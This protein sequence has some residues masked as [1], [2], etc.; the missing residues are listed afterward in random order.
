[1][2][3]KDHF[4]IARHHDSRFA[5][6]RFLI[7]F[8]MVIT[9]L[10]P[11]AESAQGIFAGGVSVVAAAEAP[12]QPQAAPNGDE[13]TTS[14]IALGNGLLPAWA[15]SLSAP[16]TEQ[17]TGTVQM[18]SALLPDWFAAPTAPVESASPLEPS[19]RLM[20][21][22]SCTTAGQLS[23]ALTVPAE[24][25]VGNVTGD[26][27]TVTVNNTGTAATT[28]ARLLVT[29][30]P[31]FYYVAG[32]AA[33]SDGSTIA[34][35]LSPANPAPGQAFTIILSQGNGSR[36]DLDGG[37]T[38]TF[39][40]RLATN[41]DAKSG[42]PLVTALQSGTGSPVTC[43]TTTENVQV[44][45]GNLTITK[46]PA[47]QTATF[48]SVIT[49]TVSL[50]N[51]GQGTLYGAQLTDTIGAGYTGF[52]ITPTPAPVDLVAG[53]KFDYTA[54]AT[55]NSCGNLTNRADATWIL[56]NADGT[57]TGANPVNETADVLL[58]IEDPTVIVDIGPLPTTGYCG[59]L[60]ATI[61]V[62]VTNTGGAARNVSLDISSSGPPGTAVTVN[63]AHTAT[64]NKSGNT[65]TY[66][67]GTLGAGASV[68]FLLDMVTGNLCSTASLNIALTPSYEDSCL[69]L[70]STGT[71][72]TES[73]TLPIEA[74][75]L[76][77]TKDGPTTMIAGNSYQYVMTVSGNNR[78]NIGAGGVVITDVVPSN[79]IIDSVT[80]SGGTP[81]TQ[82]GQNLRWNLD[83]SGTGAYN[84]Q[85]FVNVTVPGQ[86]A[87]ACGAGSS[88]NNAVTAVADIPCPECALSAS[89]NK[90]SFIY[91]FLNPTLNTFIKEAT[92]IE[93][94]GPPT[95]NVIT[96]TL[97][98]G[99]G[100][101]WTNTI[102]TD[103][104]GAGKLGQPF[105]IVPGSTRVHVDGID[106]TANV[107]ISEG[108]PLSINFGGLSAI[109]GAFS[110]TANI[111]IVYQIDGQPGTIPGGADNT[112]PTLFSQFQLNGPA[113]SCSGGI[114]G[115]VAVP[116]DVSRGSLG[117]AVEP[118]TLQACRLNTVTLTVNENTASDLTDSIAVSFTTDASDIITPTAFTVGGGFTGQTPAVAQGVQP[119]GRKIVTFTFPANFDLTGTGTIS[120][121]LFRPCEAT[122]GLTANVAYLDRCDVPRTSS[123]TGGSSTARSDLTLFTTPNQFTVVEKKAQWSFIVSNGGNTSATDFT[124][125]NELPLGTEFYT[126]TVSGS[127]PQG[128]K[129]SITYKTG[130]LAGGRNVV[131]FTVPSAPGLPN[132]NRLTFAV[133]ALVNGCA[134]P[135]NVAIRLDRVC[136]NVNGVCQGSSQGVVHLLP[137]TSS[138]LSTNNQT[139]NLPLCET[140]SVQL[141]VKN[142]SGRAVEY[143]LTITDTITNATFV[144]GSTLVSVVDSAGAPIVGTTSGQ[145]LTNIPFAP[146]ISTSGASS[147]LVWR[148]TDYVSGTAAYDVLAQRNAKDEIRIDFDV[149][150]GCDGAAVEV[151]STGS[152]VDAC[153]A[154]LG[155]LESSKS[156]VTDSPVLEITKQ[157]Q[158]VTTGSALG[159]DTS[160]APVFA[161]VGDQ[162]VWNVTVKNTGAQQVTNLFTEDQLPSNFTVGSV[163]P[164]PS[165]NTGSPPFLQWH[166]GGGQALAANGGT[167]T[168]AITGTLAP[169]ACAISPLENRA[170]TRFA[171]GTGDVC[172][173]TGVT[174]TAYISTRPN[175]AISASNATI[176]ECA[177]GPLTVAINNTGARASN[178][179]VTYT[180]PANMAY[181]GLNVASNPTPTSQPAVGATGII[182]FGYASFPGETNG[183]LQFNATNATGLCP[184]PGSN[185][186]TAD[187][188]Y[189]NTCSTD[190]DDVAAANATITV[191]RPNLSTATVTPVQQVVA[192]GQR[193]TWTISI[194]NSGSGIARNLIVT[195]TLDAGWGSITAIN[196]APGGTVP[197]IDAGNRT[198]VWNVGTLSNGQTWTATFSAIAQDAQTDYRTTLAV[199]TACDDGGCPQSTQAVTFST[200]TQGLD[201]QT[202]G[203]PVR[204][205]QPFTYTISFDFFG[206][207]TYTS[208]ILTDT[209]PKL[210]GAL[211]FS[212]TGV[213]IVNENS[214]TNNWAVGSLSGDRL[215]FTTGA[216]GTVMGPD[217]VAITV[218]GLISNALTAD[219]NDIF[220]NRADLTWVD[221]GRDYS[222]N[223]AVDGQIV[224]PILVIAKQ[225]TPNKDLQAGDEITYT[226]RVT[227]TAPSTATAFD[228]VL[229][230]AIPNFLTY[231]RGFS[232]PGASS[233][234]ATAQLITATYAQIPLGQ[235]VTITY[236]VDVHAGAPVGRDLINTAV[237]SH[238]SMPGDNPSERTGDPTDPGGAANDHNTSTT[239]GITVAPLEISKSILATNQPH[240]SGLN[241]AVGEQI[242][243][244]LL[245]TIP[246]GLVSTGLITDVLDDGLAFVACDSIVVS[247]GIGTNLA[248]DFAAACSGPTVTNNGREAV[249][250]LGTVSNTDTN[251]AT[252][253]TI[254][255]TYRVVLLNISTTNRDTKWNNR[256]TFG[257]AD[258][259]STSSAP[260]V[261]VVEPALA[262][263]KTLTPATSQANQT[264]TVTLEIAHAS[265]SNADAMTVVITDALPAGLTF[266]GGITNVSGAPFTS[267]SESGGTITFA[268]DTLPLGQRSTVRF[269]ATVDQT[270][271]PNTTIINDAF[272][273]WSSLPGDVTTAQSPFNPDATERTGDTTNPGGTANDH[274]AQSNDD[275][276][277]TTI[278]FDKSIAATNQPHTSGLN[279]AI[280]EQITYT[281]NITVPQG[282]IPTAVVADVLDTGLAFI[283]LDSVT[284]ST[285][286]TWSGPATAAFANSGER[287]VVNF[288]T[289]TNAD[290]NSATT[291]VI[292]LTYRAVVLNTT[293]NNRGDPRNN[294]ASFTWSA[295][296][297]SDT[298]PDVTI[299]EPEL[300][301][302]KSVAPTSGDAGD[303]FTFTLA[304][305][306]TGSSNTDAMTVVITDAVPAGMTFVSGSAQNVSGAATTSAS[307]SGGIVTFAWNTL[308]LGT[309]STVSFR[310][311][312]N[313]SAAPLSTLTNTAFLR[314]SSLPG[315]ITAP[316]SPENGLS[317]E[318]TGNTSD[319]GG[320]AND[321]RSQNNTSL[322]TLGYSIAKALDTTSAAHTAGANVTIG[323]VITYDL[324][325]TLPEGTTTGL[326]VVDDLPA[327]LAFVPGSVSV[328]TTG[329]NGSA[330]APTAT[331]SGGSGDDVTLTFTPVTVTGDNVT[332]NNSFVVR[333]RAR[334]LDIPGNVGVTPQTALVNRATAQVGSTPIQSTGP[335]TATVVEPRMAI[336]KSLTPNIAAANDTVTITLV[337]SNTGT[338]E[339]FEVVVDDPVA[340]AKFT[341]I[342]PVTTPAG[343]AFSTVASAPNTIVRYTGGSIP[344]GEIRTFVFTAR[345]TSGTVKGEVLTNVATVTQATTLP[346]TDAGERDEPDVSSNAPVTVSA[347]DLTL[348]KT[349][350]LTSLLPGQTTVYSLTVTNVGNSIATGVV[351]TDTVPVSTTF[352]LANSSAGWSCADNA[353]AATL[354]TFPVGTLAVNASQTVRFAV[355]LD[356]PLLTSSAQITNTANTGDDGSHGSDPTPGNNTATDIDPTILSSLGD[357]VWLDVNYDGQQGAPATE[358]PVANVRV[359]LYDSNGV[360]IATTT[361]DANGFYNFGGLG[362]GD[363]TVEFIPPA[364]YALTT[365]TVG[366]TATD[367]NANPT[368]GRTAP[369]TLGAGE[370]NPTIDAGLV[371]LVNLGDYVW[372]DADGNGQQGTPGAELPVAGVTVTLTYPN[373][374]VFTTT[375]DASGLYTFTNLLPNQTYT[376]TFTSPPG[377]GFTTQNSGA[378]TSDSDANPA[379][380]VVV[381]NLGLNDD[382]TIDAGLVQSM[383]LGNFVWFDSN[384]NGQQDGGEPGIAGAVVTL[385][386]ADGV[387]PA[388]DVNGNLITAQTTGPDGLYN[389]TNLSPGGYVVKVTMPAGYTPTPVQVADANTDSN[390]DSNIASSAAN[391]HSS[392]VVILTVDGEPASAVDGDGTNGNLSVDFGFTGVNLGDYVWLDVNGD[393]QQGNPTVE[394]PVAGVTV[395]LTYPNGVVIT[396]TTNA[397]GLYTFTNLIPNQTY[398]VTFTPPPTY[399]ITTQNSGADTSDSDANPVTGVVVVPLGVV[400]DPTI[401]AGLYIPLKIGD[402]LWIDYNADGFDDPAEPGLPGVT[403]GLYDG[404]DNLITTTVTGP[405][406]TY[407]FPDLP[408][409]TYEVRVDQTTL[410]PG[411]TNTHDL[412]GNHDSTSTVTQPSGQ[413]NLNLDFGYVGVPVLATTKRDVLFTDVDNDGV[414]SPGDVLRYTVIISNTG[415]G[416]LTSIV[417]TDTPGVNT[418][419]VV[420][421]VQTS[422]GAVIMGNGAGHTSVR[423][424]VGTLPGKT[425]ATIAFRVKI[426]SPLPAGVTQVANQGTVSSAQLPPTPT[427]DPDTGA[428]SDPTVTPVNAAAAPR[429]TKASSLV[430]DADGNGVVSPGDTLRYNLR[431]V[432][433]G[434]ATT[435]NVIFSDTPD[436]NTTLIVGSVLTNRGTVITG[437]SLGDTTVAIA[438]G[439]V[440][441]GDVVLI[442]F[443]VTVNIGLATGTVLSNQGQIAYD[444]DGDGNNDSTRPTDGDT[445]QPGDQPATN[446]IGGSPE[447]LAIKSVSDVNGGNLEPGDILLYTIVLQNIS[448]FNAPG[449]VF[450]DPIPAHTNY[451]AGSVSAP[452]ASTVVSTTPTLRISGI[453]VAAHSQV[454]ITFQVQVINPLSAGV[455]EISN[456]GV[457]FFDSDGDGNNDASQPTDGDTVNPGNQPTV[458]P[459]SAGPNFGETTKTV[460]LRTDADGNGVVTPGDTL[461]YTVRIPNTG[462]QD[463][464][465]AVFLLDTIP[466]N[467]TYV[468]GST[469][470]DRGTAS[471]NTGSNRVEWSGDVPAGLAVIITFDVTI[472]NGILSG[473]VISNQ[474]AVRYD[475]DGDGTPDSTELTDSDTTAPGEQPTTV[476]VGGSPEGVARKTA[477]DVNG[478]SLAPGDVILYTVVLQNT[479]GF[480]VPGIEFIDN[481]PSHTNYITNS[482][483]VPAGA[484]IV[485]QSPVIRVAGVDVNAFSAVTITFQ[486]QITSPLP[487]GVTQIANQ[488]TVFF[489][490]DGDGNND[491]TQPTDGDSGTPGNQPTV[492]PVAATLQY[493]ATKRDSLFTDAD[494]N[495]TPSP[496]DTIEYEI[497][498]SNTGNQ[499][500]TNVVFA[501]TPDANT[502][503]VVGSVA[504]SAGTITA[505]N[506]AGNTKVSVDIGTLNGGANV[507]IT[508]RVMVRAPL[509]AGV[510]QIANQGTLGSTELPTVI[511]D[512]PDTPT[513]ED[514]TVTPLVAAPVLAASKRD[515]LAVDADGNGTPSP[516]DTIEY[517]VTIQNT[518]NQAAT[519]LVFDD[520]P[521][522]NSTLVVGSVTTSAGTVTR[523]NGGGDTAISV[524][525][526]SLS[527]GGS[528][529]I[530]FQVTI[531]NPLPAGV[532]QIANQ[533]TLRSDQLPAVQTDDPDTP[534]GGDRTITPIA[535]E[536]LVSATKQDTLAVDADGNGSPS[537]GDTLEY[538]VTIINSGNQA[539]RATFIDNVL[540]PNVKLIIGTVQT[541]L[542]TIARGN[543][544]GDTGVQV[545]VGIIPGGGGTVVISFRV[546]INNPLPA[547]VTQVGNQATVSGSNFPTIPTDDPD[548]PA[549]GDA[550]ITP[551]VAA[552]VL[553]AS[554]RD[555]LAIDADGSGS[556]SPGDTIEY[557]VTIRNSGNSAATGVVFDDIPGNN[558]TLVVG[559]VQTSAGTVTTG[560]AAG[561]KTVSIN[562]GT[563][564]GGGSVTI[565]FRVTINDPLPAGVTRVLNQG[566]VSSEQLPTRPTD[567]PDT[568]AT[569]DPTA[570][571]VV[572]APLLSATKSD[573]VFVDADGNGIASPGDTILYQVTIQN[574]GNIAAT[575]VVFDDIPSANTALIVGTV[576]T[577]AGTVTTG[578]GPGHTTVAVNI[579]TL[580]GESTVTISFRVTINN[581]LPGGVTQIANQG[582]VHSNQLPSLPT[583]D[584]D[585]PTNGDPTLTPVV[586]E[587][588]LEATKQD[589][590]AVDADGDGI[591]SPG[592]TLLYQVTIHNSGNIAA[593]GIVFDDT[594]DANTTLVVNSVQTS[595]GTVI[596]G[597]TAGDKTVSVNIGAIPGGAS[598]TI[599]FR[600]I[601]N[602]PL[603]AGVTRVQNQGTVHS[604]QLPS[605]PTDDPDTAAIDDPTTTPLS[606][607]P[608]IDATKR[609]SLAVDADA[610]GSPSPGD[611]IEYR[612]VIA[613]SGNQAGLATFVDNL[614]GGNAL[615]VVNS[616][617]T[618]QGTITTGNN[619]GDTGVIV[620]LGTIPGGQSATITFRVTIRN[621]LPAGVTQVANQAV[622]TGDNFPDVPTDD[623]DT[624]G[625]DDPT[626]TPLVA[627]PVLEASKR[628]TL[629][630]DVDGNGVT[631]PGDI[632]EY[633]VVIRNTGNSAATGVVFND[634]PDANTVLVVGS[635][636]TSLGT[637]IIG[638]TPGHRAVSVNIDTI[639]GGG[640]AVVSFRVTI[641]KPLPAGVTQIANQGTVSS[642]DLPTVPTDDPDTIPGGDPT[643]TPLRAAPVLAVTKRDSLVVD[644]DGNGSASPDD[645][646]EYRIVIRN[647]GNQA[648]TGVV[649]NDTPDA[650]TAL[651]VG[652]VQTSVGTVT[653][654]NA[655]GQTTVSVDIGTIPGGGQV[656]ITFRVTINSPLPAGVLSIANQGRVGSN[657]LPTVPTDDPDTGAV[658]DPTKTPVVS[659]PVLEADKRDSLLIDADGDGSASPGDT[660]L[661]ETIIRNTGNVAASDVLFVDF[662][663]PN[664]TLVVGSVQSSQGTVINGN[665]AGDTGVRVN[666]G[667]IAG[668]AQVAVTFRVIVKNPLPANVNRV[669]NQGSVTSSELPTVATNDPDT[670]AV[671]DPTVTP[672]NAK[673]RLALAKTDSL[674][675]DVDGNGQPSP[676][677]ILQYR[678]VVR[679][680]GNQAAV[681]VIVQDA[682]DPFTRLVIGSV[683][684]T[685]G[686][687]TSGNTAGNTS[688]VVAVGTLPGAG[689]QAVITYRATIVTP[690]P[691]TVEQVANQA[692]AGA[693]NTGGVS[694]DD[695]DT[696]TLG[697]PTLTPV[698]AEPILDVSKRDSLFI[699]VNGDGLAGPGDTL[700]YQVTILNV[701]NRAAASLVFND[702]PD[703]NTALVVGTVQT[704]RGTV[705]TGNTAGDTTVRV[706]LGTLPG[707]GARAD[708]S[709]QMRIDDTLPAG[710]RQVAN[711]GTVSGD[712]VA[713]AVSDDPDTTTD[714]DPTRTPVVGDPIVNATKQDSLLIDADGNGIVTGG[715]TLLYQVVVNNSGN[716]AAAGVVY[717]DTPDINTMIVPGSLQTSIGTVT[718]GNAAGDR[719]IRV[720]IGE[721]PARNE[722]RISYRVTVNSPLPA[723]VKQIRNQGTVTGVAI[724]DE[725]TDDPDSPD[726]DDPTGTDL[727]AA[728]IGLAKRSQPPT[729]YT[730]LPGDHITYTLRLVNLGTIPVTN[731]VITDS[732]PVGTAFVPGSASPAQSS[733]PD[734]LVWRTAQLEVGQALTVSF[735]VEVQPVGPVVAITNVARAE[736]DQT[737]VVSSP[738]VVHPFDPTDIE[739]LSFTA[740]GTG[741]AIEVAW[742]TGAEI[743]TWGF[744]LWRGTSN[745][746]GQA[747]RVTQQLIP[748]EG[749]NGGGS[750][751]RYL[752]TD[753]AGDSLYWY[754]L[755]EMETD[756]S[757]NEYGPVSGRLSSPGNGEGAIAPLFL[758][759][760]GQGVST[761]PAAPTQEPPPGEAEPP[762]EANGGTSILLPL[763][764]R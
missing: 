153:G 13:T 584:P 551:V 172:F 178:V 77:V 290:S 321:H 518:G 525:I 119:D 48:G 442:S 763:I 157:V 539:G 220:T 239:E 587:V 530:T 704:N 487:A 683:Q 144:N 371:K 752:D 277:S 471:F 508:F 191:Q 697:D 182:T 611:T 190:F 718:T 360:L 594:P 200:P 86:G 122:S 306:H 715:D 707:G 413:D 383:N 339:A 65:I 325:I 563:I 388:R 145:A 311:T 497:V 643:V 63:P 461:R 404:S 675:T 237:I 419:L 728:H 238:T 319:P 62:T 702:T 633:R 418:A 385:F 260:D 650:N 183:S 295:G 250:N 259:T 433:T 546:T 379:T 761:E 17:T 121:P 500:V 346:G 364:G 645:R 265:G 288:G 556:A 510:T 344:V 137:G 391:V 630:V 51:T 180:L 351:L 382:P 519:G 574:S 98:V 494:G 591:P 463:S 757:R 534:A 213:T 216:A 100:I 177:G 107:A 754:W 247:P 572:A 101:T 317:T 552:P 130:T 755:E 435:A 368:T 477:T 187:M 535:A 134:L 657:E 628:D 454:L 680:T 467:T 450:E 711:Q 261:T 131:T 54:Q 25:S 168:Y 8:S 759:L 324:T 565:T 550:T 719:T 478:G 479:S 274:R 654:G 682:P 599:S 622:V 409:G 744:H 278:A 469:A 343:F 387:T 1:M 749:R 540:D 129:D 380:G 547:G 315:D 345:L 73:V 610:S 401:D 354:C 336:V 248:G 397:S 751:Y 734:P 395:T 762:A 730:V 160:A 626:I 491:T 559:S 526:G 175:F 641:V 521:D 56:G 629:A 665:N 708:I 199:T 268:W 693:D 720:D 328:D 341:G 595:V 161:G 226:L 70:R 582:T 608:A 110:A 318:R 456:Q 127:A 113:Q 291:E 415:T 524:S 162:L 527:G 117:V 262:I 204:I 90:E 434:N 523:G 695:P 403:V 5:W 320:A 225:A 103:T 745:D 72:D 668:G 273:R 569:N 426:D 455:D 638:N 170:S 169:G 353:A 548:T 230:D 428:G 676:G 99:S 656:V 375:T 737:S 39:N 243:Y 488:G 302:A 541:T 689:G 322:S 406:G 111:V 613:N 334:V 221:D 713:P 279:V 655:A 542:G 133:D 481:I 179:V 436:A 679:N 275:L 373:G 31:G 71:P 215:I 427:D 389:F 26:L 647:S 604:D 393:G 115:Y 405:D 464:L 661:Y 558:I 672:I 571:P 2:R 386:L 342:T 18:G 68:V 356:L 549:N 589:T 738:I 511:T 616:V 743:D 446:P 286:V 502:T 732:V 229:T 472:N 81:V 41:T 249:F 605:L 355:T 293:G 253:E 686:T 60:S 246:Q 438:V 335:V 412:D 667:T 272:L 214:G 498:A 462:N 69:L 185:T 482:L 703:P 210:D 430:R 750:I 369:V 3:P 91:D 143:N 29:P 281:I 164:T 414:A 422:L 566:E 501:D 158:N 725:T 105:T 598:V 151:R 499:A 332:A 421:S 87:G 167:I 658:D 27:F 507:T 627:A 545:N 205:G 287:M 106:R 688:V 276:S 141:R 323:E 338:S 102:Y 12:A 192:A 123:A 636:Q 741:Q 592:D 544:P 733:G 22:G 601:I 747:V 43:K 64:W 372:L 625:A 663:D 575:N 14:D 189:Q 420:N 89:A 269:L 489:D 193:Y 603:T 227:N 44:V 642:N 340:D 174:T 440:N 517:A 429:I 578:N 474:G 748:A 664:T 504:T 104:L 458:I 398:T 576:Q 506:G 570:T 142:T 35:T 212:P 16:G 370:H 11:L 330:A 120:F 681:N 466:A 139:A 600:V 84:E 495:S 662:P 503:L 444:S 223:D 219:N 267:S 234:G 20:A 150:T 202:I 746:R 313:Q 396:T 717:T 437:N 270:V 217:S 714:N 136:G 756:G 640:Q 211:V 538:R 23:A 236:V 400:D 245:V 407:L 533:G 513:T 727:G 67:P 140:G 439:D 390:T 729:G 112:V 554:K 485:T 660:I 148:V 159:G 195:E 66:T 431:M 300:T 58:Q 424:N 331:S 208:A 740:N 687:V 516:D 602:T 9:Y 266:A 635:V 425:S 232:A 606:A 282:T 448:S 706:N 78:Q 297:L 696:P 284:A 659:A 423:V 53:A 305:T 59:S 596:T 76:S 181:A 649:F 512:D 723:G 449:L 362:A 263:T 57:A 198:V 624:P 490:S 49:W 644:A 363:Y 132:G 307:E 721:L 509:P 634:I 312:L 514:P 685:A 568:T 116:I 75:S 447:G 731:V 620:S 257:W 735:R 705:V 648:A 651:V 564:P 411:F 377:Y 149:K 764:N 327:G 445:T 93:L 184:A 476:P 79:L 666:I 206:G 310:A 124:V 138:L 585:T 416:P 50:E 583:D 85:F 146:N 88:L 470:A 154:P 573:R 196:G 207:R 271:V 684:T 560:N 21:A 374:T 358:T 700:L 45:R 359:N 577:N 561:H 609:D 410:P 475:T 34:V 197:T 176:Q 241:V 623:P 155:F 581:P 392:N 292:T 726:L 289:I 348:T 352:D 505:G 694:S 228:V 543:N 691:A 163:S 309:G 299:V 367:S 678:L 222:L 553:A 617:Q 698:V 32:S 283:T 95:A 46:S 457:V 441:P 537:P 394:L 252:V 621:P 61:P 580:P 417:F 562:V 588:I 201:K 724:A 42:Q 522:A 557:Q 244:T 493:S 255:V 460:A 384:A 361:T 24:V 264:V 83:T 294:Q 233:S 408:P 614:L 615:L 496:G 443:D 96:A 653:S 256:A 710:V 135:D 218:T 671:D 677:D 597:N 314:W 736:T 126:Y 366:N 173:S 646:L 453:D 692:L 82:N 258:G 350:N 33:A 97:Q 480:N 152:A 639:P 166:S 483:T 402:T 709:F 632:L 329:F 528:V 465:G 194:P 37:E 607:A 529:T 240:T 365:Q 4:P 316:Q 716:R 699:D 10:S 280:G 451:L 349:N 376:V 209:L 308:A 357:Y 38:I 30:S 722:A 40:F 224:E 486:A 333:L 742:L 28:E 690:V 326:V 19:A 631:S 108:P 114:T 337:V 92:P 670:P 74:P 432:N 536:P 637:V 47:L 304:I 579:G 712:N 171:C 452:G 242:T 347:P 109:L 701:G 251:A 285:G 128:V 473:I 484:T 231:S 652:T 399:A 758:P 586:A 15:E 118:G 378:D 590:L 674:F 235:S 36:N 254:L 593:T 80:S 760:V 459:V 186:G 618:S 165:S 669:V 125:V 555:T 156:L 147:T 301:I 531:K 52:S 673:P 739:L 468:N 203:S 532:A 6:L 296:S 619:P 753:V 303:V 612:I 492:S 7:V 55:I 188:R 515:R 520:T 94:C 298:A 567:D 381:V